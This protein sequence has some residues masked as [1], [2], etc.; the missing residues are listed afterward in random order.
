MN[1]L[2]HLFLSGSSD[3]LLIGNFIADHIKGFDSSQFPSEILRGIQLH[4]MIDN[5]TDQHEVVK[6]T[7]KKFYI[8]TKKYTPV[9]T[10]VIYDHFLIHHW[11]KFSSIPLE[12]F[13]S[14]TFKIIKQYPGILP[15]KSVRFTSYL[16]NYDW[17]G[18]YATLEGLTYIFSQ[19]DKRTSFPSEL[20]K[21]TLVLE[22]HYQEIQDEFLMFFPDLYNHVKNFP[23]YF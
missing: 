20:Y 1:I 15:E 22:E 13:K 3:E 8:T 17:I 18:H 21:S 14:R 19:M 9:A 4:R 12:E 5:F 11:D 7:R 10:D 23:G 16:I 2:A 6:Q